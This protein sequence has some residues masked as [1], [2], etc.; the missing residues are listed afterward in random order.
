M[1]KIIT[2][3]LS[4]ISAYSMAS[5]DPK[6][7]HTMVLK[8]KAAMVDVREAS[9]IKFGMIEEAVWF[10][11][12]WAKTDQTWYKHFLPMTENKE[13]IFIYCRTGRRSEEFRN[14]LQEKG[15]KA[16]NLGGFETLK[17]VLPVM[18]PNDTVGP[19]L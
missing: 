1:K 12:S 18:V 17:E 19:G 11:L 16:E 5:T 7:A 2:S 10:P 13:K 14:L 8:G 4:F 15:V 3:L 6:V 9:E